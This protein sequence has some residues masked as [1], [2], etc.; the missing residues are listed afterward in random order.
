MVAPIYIQIPQKFTCLHFKEFFNL[1]WEKSKASDKIVI[2]LS[3]TE[4]ISLEGIVLLFS[5]INYIKIFNKNVQITVI[6]PSFGE[7]DFERKIITSELKKYPNINSIEKENLINSLINSSRFRRR[8]RFLSLMEVW[9]IYESCNLRI[10]ESIEGSNLIN[11]EIDKYRAKL[12]DKYFHKVVPFK[13]INCNNL[14]VE[15]NTEE[16]HEFVR[17]N[18]EA[19]LNNLYSL[20]KDVESILSSNSSFTPFENKSLSH[21]ITNELILNVA[22]HAF[23]NKRNPYNEC[24]LAISLNKKLDNKYNDENELSRKIESNLTNERIAESWNFFKQGKKNYQNRSYVEFALVD[25]GNGIPSTL[26]EKFNEVKKEN[27]DKKFNSLKIEDQILEFAFELDS[28]RNSL[29]KNFEIQPLVPRGLYFLLETVRL[30]R[31]LLFVRSRKGRV[32]YDFSINNDVNDNILINSE[33][34][35]YEFPGTFY[36]ILLPD[37]EYK[38]KLQPFEK[39]I[40]PNKKIVPKVEHWLM[41]SLQNEALSDSLNIKINNAEHIAKILSKID[42]KLST[43]KEK[44][45]IYLD[46]VAINTIFLDLKLFYYLCNTPK[47]N[48]YINIVIINYPKSKIDFLKYIQN[49]ISNI[50]P[51]IFRPIPCIY[52][53]ETTLKNEVKVSYHATW[54]GIKHLDEEKKINDLLK[55]GIDAIYPTSDFIEPNTLGGN[56]IQID[57]VD[58]GKNFG[59]ITKRSSLLPSLEEIS[60]QNCIFGDNKKIINAILDRVDFL[61][62]ESTKTDSSKSLNKADIFLDGGKNNQIFLTSGGY[63]QNEFIKLIDIFHRPNY[64]RTFATYLFNKFLFE[65][66]F[67]PEVDVIVSVT[68]SSSLLSKYVKEVYRQYRGIYENSN[69]KPELIRLAHYYE[70]EKEDSLETLK[71]NQ[72]VLLVNDVISTGQL[73]QKLVNSIEKTHSCLVTAIF[74][75]VDSRKPNKKKI[76]ENIK[77]SIF[78]P[79]IDSKTISLTEYPIE[80]YLSYKG[81]KKIIRINPIINSPSEETLENSL[82]DKVLNYQP[83]E[84]KEILK[85]IDINFLKIGY[86]K[87]NHHYHYYTID[88]D[89]LLVSNNGKYLLEKLLKQIQKKEKNIDTKYDVLIYPMFSAPEFVSDND[90]KILFQNPSLT[91]YPLPR[92]NTPK[93][94]RLTLPTKIFK[95]LVNEQSQV[96]LLDDGSCSGDTLIQMIDFVSFLNVKSITVLSIFGRLEDFEREFIS[97]VDNLVIKNKERKI[98]LSV[99]FGC[100]LH[101]PFYHSNN[102]QFRSNW[103]NIKNLL[104]GRDDFSEQT[105]RYL[106]NKKE[107]FRGANIADLP[108]PE[109]LDYFPIHNGLIPSIDLMFVRNLLGHIEGYRLFE[110]YFDLFKINFDSN[111]KLNIEIL[112]GVINHEPYLLTTIKHI[113][114]DI[115]DKVKEYSENFLEPDKY[116]YKWSHYGLCRFKSIIDLD[117]FF[118][119]E[120]LKHSIEHYNR[121]KEEDCIALIFENILNAIIKEEDLA[122]YNSSALSLINDLNEYFFE[123]EEVYDDKIFYNYFRDIVAIQNR[124]YLTGNLSAYFLELNQYFNRKVNFTKHL[125]LDLSFQDIMLEL[126]NIESDINNFNKDFNLYKKEIVKVKKN[127]ES[128]VSYNILPKAIYINFPLIESFQNFIDDFNKIDKKKKNLIKNNFESYLLQEHAND[129]K[130]DIEEFHYRYLEFNKDNIY[131]LPNISNRFPSK[132]IYYLINDFQKKKGFD[133][134]KL[135]IE[136]LRFQKRPLLI[137]GDFLKIIFEELITNAIE[138]FNKKQETL[139]IKELIINILLHEEDY[140]GNFST[141]SFD[142][143]LE[144]DLRKINSGSSGL[145]LIKSIIEGFGGIF[146][147]NSYN[148]NFKIPI[149]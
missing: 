139:G 116:Y 29:S 11:K 5:F 135:N 132:K 32:L 38:V 118:N 7:T 12:G 10:E 97:R 131:S 104:N 125:T 129:L 43:I 22:H 57:W 28:S 55:F 64:G 147:I 34:E 91:I 44:T 3:N 26:I 54:I 122:R 115:F 100:H 23:E 134:L 108:S 96:F 71:P 65:K 25:F 49:I 111:S 81:E 24:Y 1:Y 145:Y 128:I 75:V 109:L 98:K 77:E 86:I 143:N 31:G 70:F 103:I 36:N 142:Q 87:N 50:E 45:L 119:F 61:T 66:K 120:T 92:V 126:N 136:S 106:E 52:S 13:K 76:S 112:M 133:F 6:M 124:N 19:E 16:A 105:R 60:F 78:D 95:N 8:Q 63:Y 51:F 53:I 72:K 138:E 149:K 79:Y 141:I 99:Y 67:L 18:I 137:C 73:V 27:V 148:F 58:K 113:L 14:V 89:N 102:C 93:G 80:K 90:F 39:P 48:E 110:E 85:I 127:I 59:N 47:I 30:Y 82:T 144:I 20:S 74:S 68:L 88:T 4:W 117:Y 37:S 35:D 9:K 114:P 42:N 41:I 69:K 56:I 146:S 2:N 94:W 140:K 62:F 121:N 46:F 101:I 130:D 17:Q 107:V 40:F 84:L 123:N 33:V 21:I 83:E 15:E